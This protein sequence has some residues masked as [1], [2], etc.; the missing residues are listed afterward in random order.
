[1]SATPFR[2]QSQF[3]NLLRLL[4]HGVVDTSTGQSFDAFAK[5]V[6]ARRLREVVQDP[7]SG[8][9]VVWRRQ[10]DE[11]VKS[12]SGNRIFPNLT[13]VRPHRVKIDDP[14]T[15]LLPEPSPQFLEL[16]SEVKKLVSRIARSHG[17]S[18][19]GFATA[20]LEK[21]LTSSSVAGACWLFS[22]AVRHTDWSTQDA[23]RN[24]RSEGT[25]G[26]RSLIRQISQRIAQY[27]VQGTTGFATVRFPSDGFEFEARGLA[28]AGVVTDIYKYSRALRDGANDRSS[29]IA[30]DSEICDLVKAA[31]RIMAL[32]GDGSVNVGAEDA[33]LG[34]LRELL[35]RHPNDRFLVFTESLQ[36]CEALQ[37]ALGSASR[38]LVGSMTKSDRY[39]A[40]ADLCNP[41]MN[42]RVLVATS[43]A[44]EGLDLQVA[45]KVIHWDLSSSPATLMQR[46]GRVARLGQVSDVTAY[47]LILAGTHEQRRDDALQ[48]RFASLGIVDEA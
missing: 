16:L 6:D 42:A 7:E 15:P 29:W 4:T 21:K 17:Q 28:Q 32:P 8:A 19:G 47:Y 36:T 48:A 1:M 43:A 23:F 9:T 5:T 18:F 34:W 39:R 13:I 44:D 45:S 24:D 25:E 30:E 41:R 14:L 38:L 22:W 27:N 3:V 40:V 10:S 33:K 26:L 31:Q 12:W 2:S 20:Q 46:N 37:N 11:I 35:S